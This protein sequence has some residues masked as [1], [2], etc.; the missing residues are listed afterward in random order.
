MVLEIRQQ[1]KGRLFQTL[2]LT[3][4]KRKV[5]LNIGVSDMRCYL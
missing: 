4:Y 1:L 3:F 5:R 2:L